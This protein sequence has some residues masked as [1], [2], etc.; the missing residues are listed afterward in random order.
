LLAALAVAAG[1]L[2]HRLSRHDPLTDEQEIA[3]RAVGYMD[4]LAAPYQTT[5]YEWF[6]T[7]PWWVGLSFHD[8][9]PLLFAV[10]HVVFRIFGD[11]L[12]AL[13]VPFALLGIAS[14]VLL[15][16]LARHLYGER[17]AAVVLALGA[18]N[19]Y[20]LWTFRIGLQEGPVIFFLLASLYCLMR[21][22]DAPRW[23]VAWGTMAGLG[24]LTKYTA[25]VVFPISLAYLCIVTPALL[26]RRELWIGLLASAVVFSPVVVYNLALLRTVGHFDLQLATL[27]GQATPEWTVL[28]GKAIGSLSGRLAS[29]GPE[30]WRNATWP[31]GVLVAASLLVMLVS[32]QRS[33]TRSANLFVLVALLITALLVVAIGPSQRF[34]AMLVPFALLA[35]A[36][37]LAVPF[38]AG[39]LARRAATAGFA[40]VLLLQGLVS[41][42]TL[43]AEAPRGDGLLA[44]SREYSLR[45][46]RARAVSARSS[47]WRASRG[48]P[49]AAGA[50]AFHRVVSDSPPAAHGRAQAGTARRLRPAHQQRGQ[51]LAL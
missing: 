50:A 2:F 42:E 12:L 30:F 37:A 48:D 46:W 15:G 20:W 49:G 43:H 18:V 39:R 35:C 27:L 41:F 33:G 17:V 4:F 38:E 44:V 10:E 19:T 34:L 13:R 28:P 22:R 8:H 45:L 36:S 9:P 40:A 21:A 11:S 26:R 25:V 23:L 32:L 3:F 6:A 14:L 31:F 7:P 16:A 47:R 51:T 29:L 5:P 1:L 24:L